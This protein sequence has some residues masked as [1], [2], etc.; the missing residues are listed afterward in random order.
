MKEK[1]MKTFHLESFANYKI[2]LA[3]LLIC[4]FI[5]SCAKQGP[6]ENVIK[7]AKIKTESIIE[8]VKLSEETI[9]GRPELVEENWN[10][11]EKRYELHYHI[12]TIFGAA[13]TDSPTAYII[14]E[15]D[16]WKYQ[17]RFD[18]YYESVIETQ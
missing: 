7:E 3:V 6:P 17:F 14:K 15:G 12:E 9:K 8:R 1:K 5:L 18:K 4:G 11:D 10:K 13:I 2:F 16:V